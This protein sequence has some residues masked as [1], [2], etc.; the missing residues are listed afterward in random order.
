MDSNDWLD[1]LVTGA[2]TLMAAL[3][4]FLTF[5]RRRIAKVSEERDNGNGNGN[6]GA[7]ARVLTD[8]A[9]AQTRGFEMSSQV[10]RGLLDLETKTRA[11][12]K[13]SLE[14]QIE[15]LQAEVR[16]LSDENADL[17][18]RLDRSENNVQRLSEILKSLQKDKP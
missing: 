12:E 7:A 9:A 8:M 15:E 13:A 6:G 17:R 10:L 3:T 4:V 11:A 16:R 18:L 14:A 5:Q 1:R 2:V